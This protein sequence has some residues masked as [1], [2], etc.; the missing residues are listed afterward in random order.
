MKLHPLRFL[1]HEELPIPIRF[2]IRLDHI[3]IKNPEHKKMLRTIKSW[4]HLGFAITNHQVPITKW[5]PIPPHFCCYGLT[6]W[7]LLTPVGFLSTVP[8]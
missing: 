1:I 6:R 8:G 4:Y 7:I 2:S 5:G 3:Q